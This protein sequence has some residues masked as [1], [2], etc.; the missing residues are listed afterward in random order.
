VT[1][2]ASHAT[3]AAGTAMLTGATSVCARC[4]RNANS[5]PGRTGVQIAQ[6]LASLEAAG[7]GS[8]D[9]LERARAAVHTY[10]LAAVR[11][12]A[13]TPPITAPAATPPI[14]APGTTP[15]VSTPAPR[16]NEREDD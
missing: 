11:R 15:P 6:V 8:K 14:T 13:E 10:N 7:P 2:H 1:C 16:R 9:A 12:A 5:G 4:H 3:Q